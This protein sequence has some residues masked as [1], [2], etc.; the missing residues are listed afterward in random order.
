V[1]QVASEAITPRN[2]PNTQA[3]AIC[4]SSSVP[5]ESGSMSAIFCNAQ[6]KRTCVEAL[7]GKIYFAAPW[8]VL[9]APSDHEH[10]GRSTLQAP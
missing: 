6:I 5:I 2:R 9:P 1:H 3:A 7:V 8:R 4:W 10:P